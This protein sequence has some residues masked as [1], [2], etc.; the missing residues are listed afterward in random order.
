[1]NVIGTQVESIWMT[2]DCVDK[3]CG[4][5]KVVAAL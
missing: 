5:K 2:G 3:M 1:M 4:V